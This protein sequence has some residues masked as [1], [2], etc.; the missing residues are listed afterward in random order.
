[1]AATFPEGYFEYG[2]VKVPVYGPRNDDRLPMY[3]HLDI[4]A[5][6]IPKPDKKT[7]WQGEWVFSIY[8]VYNRMNS[9][10]LT[11]RQNDTTGA[12]EASRLSIF[13]I[14]PSVTYN[15]KF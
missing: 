11:F 14:I 2:G 4:S 5:T 10:A 1:M 15:F 3:H 8:N 12:N 7:G 9:A 6:Y 13:G